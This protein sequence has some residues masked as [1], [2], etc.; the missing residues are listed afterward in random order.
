MNSEMKTQYKISAIPEN[1]CKGYSIQHGEQALKLIV[2]RSDGEIYCFHN[3]CPHTGVNLDWMPDQFLDISGKLL[4]CST[5]GALFRINDG[6][7]ISGPC[8]GQSLTRVNL[9]VKKEMFEIDLNL[10]PK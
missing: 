1:G 7:C 10:E 2:A 5:H 4:Q 9:S 8:S 6:Y 3:R